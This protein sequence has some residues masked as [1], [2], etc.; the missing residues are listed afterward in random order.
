MEDH[1]ARFAIPPSA[2]PRLYD[3]AAVWL[4]GE[5]EPVP[6]V[7]IYGTGGALS[8]RLAKGR[9]I[10]AANVRQYRRDAEPVDYHAART[11]LLEAGWMLDRAMDLALKGDAEIRPA[12]LYRPG[13]VIAAVTIT[14]R[15]LKEWIRMIDEHRLLSC[16][17]GV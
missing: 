10:C 17:I 6:G 7:T 16:G 8:F 13:N 4:H 5:A 2:F 9:T 11:E 12:G 1:A 3:K 15:A 14:G